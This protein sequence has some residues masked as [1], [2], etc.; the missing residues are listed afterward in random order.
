MCA[1]KRHGGA[2]SVSHKHTNTHACAWPAAAGRLPRHRHSTPAQLTQDAPTRSVPDLTCLRSVDVASSRGFS[3]V[4]RLRHPG[5]AGHSG[6]C[7]PRRE[8]DWLPVPM[9]A[10]SLF[11]WSRAADPLSHGSLRLARSALPEQLLVGCTS[12]TKPAALPRFTRIELSAR[13]RPSGRCRCKRT[14]RCTASGHFRS[15]QRNGTGCSWRQS[16]V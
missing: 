2:R 16:C 7:S 5:S 4:D 15:Q 9:H 14:K 11:F 13:I 10:P 8:A 12:N 6:A 3:A 1:E